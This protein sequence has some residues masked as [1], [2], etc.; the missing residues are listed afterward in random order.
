MA[1]C[2]SVNVH[3]FKKINN[4]NDYLNILNEIL[5]VKKVWHKHFIRSIMFLCKSS[6][7]Q[8]KLSIK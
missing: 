5:V 3:K 8:K 1:S 2:A 7:I 6:K 4:Y